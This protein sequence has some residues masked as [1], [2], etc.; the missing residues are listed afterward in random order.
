MRPRV[1]RLGAGDPATLWAEEPATPFHIGL[2]GLLGAGRLVDG[3][4]RPRLQELRP[5]GVAD[6][7]D[8]LGVEWSAVAGMT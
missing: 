4:G 3:R 6:N 1:E 7:L 2:A 5:A 8:R